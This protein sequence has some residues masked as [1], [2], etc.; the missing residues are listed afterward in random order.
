MLY[1]NRAKVL[2][3]S[4]QDHV[5]QVK[6]RTDSAGLLSDFTGIEGTGI[7]HKHKRQCR[8]DARRPGPGKMEAAVQQR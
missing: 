2:Q 7:S 5:M 1:I 8:L 4:S 3:T 6:S